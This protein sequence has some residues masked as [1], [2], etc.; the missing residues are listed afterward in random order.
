MRSVYPD[1]KKLSPISAPLRWRDMESLK[2]IAALVFFAFLALVLWRVSSISKLYKK[3][4][5]EELRALLESLR[6]DAL[7][8]DTV[9][10]GLTT[11][12]PLMLCY[13]VQRTGAGEVHHISVSTPIS[14]AHAVGTYFLALAEGLLRLEAYPGEAFVSENHVF[15]MVREVPEV[16][17]A[18]LEAA[19]MRALQDAIATVDVGQLRLQ[20]SMG[21]RRVGPSVAEPVHND[22]PS[23]A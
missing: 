12:A 5:L 6:G 23:R 10:P 22:S 3:A 21:M 1:P 14:P 4:H 9:V 7:S 20:R 18:A 19:P 16:E 11:T 2:I 17:R 15:H 13:S 8:S